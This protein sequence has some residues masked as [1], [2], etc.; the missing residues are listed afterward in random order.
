MEIFGIAIVVVLA[1]L[2]FFLLLQFGIFA[3]K[4]DNLRQQ[5]S[6]V[7]LAS[8]YTN[9]LLRTDTDCKSTDI[10]QLII[11]WAEH[12]QNAADYTSGGSIHCPTNSGTELSSE[13]VK[14]IIQTTLDKSLGAQKKGYDFK[15]MINQQE[16]YR[17]QSN[18][19]CPHAKNVERYPLPARVPVV[20]ELAICD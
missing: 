6:N 8:L 20:V 16:A 2:G 12:P 13:R 1:L 14:E 17:G 7:Q 18:N 15:I 11:D 9:T 10:S 4:S 19:G 5:V 3:P